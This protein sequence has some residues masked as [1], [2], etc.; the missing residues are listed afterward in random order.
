MLGNFMGRWITNIVGKIASDSTIIGAF[1]HVP[2]V[3]DTIYIGR[4]DFKT[5][6]Y[7]E[8]SRYAKNGGVIKS[9]VIMVDR[10]LNCLMGGM[11]DPSGFGFQAFVA[12]FVDPQSS[13]IK[14]V[15][16]SDEFF[17]A[18]PNPASFSLNIQIASARI[19]H[20]SYIISVYTT[21]GQKLVRSYT[22]NNL[23]TQI[24]IGNIKPGLYLLELKDLKNKVAYPL[25][26]III[27]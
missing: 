12:R 14:D 8:Y 16:G 4:E 13:S 24:D 18:Y 2:F 7:H 10:N 23:T 25:K 3:L 9:K 21:L 15:P 5:G 27:N 11:H 22:L 19:T 1:I 20:E 6:N 26:K 17:L